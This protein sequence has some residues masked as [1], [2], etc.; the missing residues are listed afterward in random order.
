M[1]TAGE[2]P[3]PAAVHH[4]PQS[5]RSSAAIEHVLDEL[6]AAHANLDIDDLLEGRI[7]VFS[8]VDARA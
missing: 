1:T 7:Q 8:T 4:S 5:F 3:L 6:T 2:R